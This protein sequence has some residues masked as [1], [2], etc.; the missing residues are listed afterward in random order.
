MN[1]IKFLKKIADEEGLIFVANKHPGGW[2]VRY[3]WP[4]DPEIINE[5]FKI[6]IANEDTL[7]SIIPKVFK[8]VKACHEDRCDYFMK[9]VEVFKR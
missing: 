5:D 9:T 8:V 2:T 3:D 7:M 4:G 1:R 6:E